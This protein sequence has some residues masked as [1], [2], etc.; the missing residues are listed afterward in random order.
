MKNYKLYNKFL[1]ILIKKMILMKYD[2]NRK[3][4][5]YLVISPELFFNFFI[6][7]YPAD[8]I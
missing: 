8:F 1:G 6:K 5:N 4:L 2:L 3:Y 7:F